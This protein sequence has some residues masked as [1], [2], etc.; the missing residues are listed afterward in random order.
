MTQIERIQQERRMKWAEENIHIGYAE[1][2]IRGRK[3]NN[4]E[5]F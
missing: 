1:L 2:K 3:K 5:F 4:M